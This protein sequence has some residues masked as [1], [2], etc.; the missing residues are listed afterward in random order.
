MSLSVEEVVE[1]HLASWKLILHVILKNFDTIL[2]QN[3]EI[4]NGAKTK[5]KCLH[6][7]PMG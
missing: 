2:M 1:C 5:V 7:V 3:D 6:S 4:K